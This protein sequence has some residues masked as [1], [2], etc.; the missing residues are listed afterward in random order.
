MTKKEL[1]IKMERNINTLSALCQKYATDPENE[2]ARKTY[3]NNALWLMGYANGLIESGVID[4]KQF[5]NYVFRIYK[6]LEIC[7]N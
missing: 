5:N 1:Y 6:E 4:Q 3:H 7:P 2:N